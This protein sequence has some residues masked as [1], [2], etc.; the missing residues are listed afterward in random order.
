MEKVKL[1]Y[2][3]N[4]DKEKYKYYV[5]VLG[6]SD[7]VKRIYF[8]ASGMN[9]YIIYNKQ[10]GKEYADERRRLYINRHKNKEDWDNP[11]TAGFWSRYLLWEE[12]TIEKAYSKI[13]KFLKGRNLI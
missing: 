13:K 7:K 5:N 1:Y 12:P 6:T 10:R 3:I 4:S 11:N 9:D 2:P 8:G